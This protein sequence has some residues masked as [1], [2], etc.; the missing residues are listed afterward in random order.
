MIARQQ[1]GDH[2]ALAYNH[3][4]I[5]GLKAWA[6]QTAADGAE[7]ARKMAGGQGYVVISG[8]PDI[9][10]SCAAMATFEGDNY[11]L[12]QQLAE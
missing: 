12:L 4:L 8:L 3:T 5:C 11:V 2:S 7:D 1:Q 9:A 6:T 10:S